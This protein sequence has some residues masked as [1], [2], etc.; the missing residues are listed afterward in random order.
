M[1]YEVYRDIRL[2]GTP[3]ENIGKFGGETDNWRWPRHT[4]DFSMFR[5]YSNSDNK[6]A[7]FSK[8]NKP[9]NPKHFLPV[10]IKGVKEGDQ[11]GFNGVT[12]PGEQL[13]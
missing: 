10:S 2:V 5:I 11:R 12:H 13:S 6:P 7:D 1:Y 9:Y 4:C 8:D 3:P